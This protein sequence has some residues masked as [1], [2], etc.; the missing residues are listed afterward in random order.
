MN[1]THFD[2]IKKLFETTCPQ[3][4]EAKL[5]FRKTRPKLHL[6][7]KCAVLLQILQLY[8]LN[9][10]GRHHHLHH[11][12]RHHHH[13]PHCHHHMH[14]RNQNTIP[15]SVKMP[16]LNTFGKHSQNEKKNNSHS[17]GCLNTSRTKIPGTS[18][19]MYRDTR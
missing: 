2:H 3:D 15:L 14:L 13:H 18:I 19:G 11:Y 7:R 16:S 12:H 10:A 6:Q 4:L 9:Q 8:F 17:T 1:L 5:L